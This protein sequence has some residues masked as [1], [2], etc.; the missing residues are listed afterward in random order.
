MGL[1]FISDGRNFSYLYETA[2]MR[3]LRFGLVGIGRQC[4][5]GIHDPDRVR[6]GI[7]FCNNHSRGR[8]FSRRHAVDFDTCSATTLTRKTGVAARCR[9]QAS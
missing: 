8:L 7:R 5:T 3:C 9:G 2:C 6:S 4:P 1:T